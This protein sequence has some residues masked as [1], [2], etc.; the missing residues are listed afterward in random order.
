[1]YVGQTD[2]EISRK[3][4]KSISMIL[5]QTRSNPDMLYIS[6]TR[7][8]NTALLKKL[9]AYSRRKIKVNNYIHM[10]GFIFIKQ[11]NKN[12]S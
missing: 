1:V 2:E 11:L 5:H 6:C 10:N 8:T 9:W 12:K 4:T 3:D 7:I